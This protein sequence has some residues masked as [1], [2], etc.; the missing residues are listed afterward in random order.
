MP[1]ARSTTVILNDPSIGITLYPGQAPV[2]VTQAQ[3]DRLKAQGAEILP[4][5]DAYPTPHDTEAD[6]AN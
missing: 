2:T 5:A 1:R 6:E 3:A 4:D